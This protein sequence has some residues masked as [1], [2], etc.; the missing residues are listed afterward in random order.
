MRHRPA[1]PQ[2]RVEEAAQPPRRPRV[3]REAAKNRGSRASSCAAGSPP[4]WAG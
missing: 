1:G 3:W 2:H 4:A